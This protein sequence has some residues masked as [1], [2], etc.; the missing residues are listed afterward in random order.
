MGKIQFILLGIG[1]ILIV[2]WLYMDET[3]KQK[4]VEQAFKPND[5]QT[6]E[7][8]QKPETRSPEVVASELTVPWEIAF[9]PN[10]DILTTERPGTLRRLGS[11]NGS[12][13]ISGVRANGESGL[14]GL[15]LHPEFE[16]N[17]YVYLYFTI[18]NSTNKVVRF[19]LENNQLI[20][21]RTIIENIPGANNHDGGRI[22]FGPDKLLYITT[23]DAQQTSLAQDTNSLAG[24]ILRVTDEGAIPTGNPFNNAVYSYGHRNP[25]GLAWDSRGRLWS[26]EHGRSGIS[27]GLDELNLIERGANYGWPTIQGDETHDGMKAPV[28]HS[29]P[30]TTWAPGGIAISGET[31]YFV[32]LRGQALYQTNIS[33]DKV[34][35]VTSRF[36][37]QYGRLR[38]IQ[39]HD[40]QLYFSTSNRDGRGKASPQDDQIIKIK[41]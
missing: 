41:L 14:L 8:E 27:T 13:P 1:F 40:G 39:I 32:G 26:T 33:G 17:N 23:G 19:R 21:D 28:A 31:I 3:V 4:V 30:N 9:L 25:Q 34:G 22:A 6:Q 18:G 38:A 16:S 36:T 10:G 37:G 5:Q 29:G 24:K 12:F 20:E 2:G 11:Q 7:I 15:A 35:P